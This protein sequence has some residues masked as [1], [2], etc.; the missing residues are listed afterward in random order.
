MR[1]GVDLGGT[2]IEALALADD[3]TELSRMR[4]ST[5]AQDYEAL[6][7]S[8]SD[9]IIDIEQKFGKARS[10]GFGTPGSIAPDTGLMQNS[11]STCLNGKNLFNDLIEQLDRPVRIANDADCFTLSEAVDGAARDFT[12]VFGVI[13]G[14]GVGGGLVINKSLLS[15][16][17][18]LTG[19]WGHNPL[20]I[21]GCL[22]KQCYCGR[23]GCVESWI[24]GPAVAEDHQ[25]KTGEVFTAAEI[26]QLKTYQAQ[27]TIDRF[28]SRLAKSLGQVI[29]IL[30]PEC[31]VFGGGLSNIERIYSELPSLVAPYIMSGNCRTSFRKAQ[32]GDS[33]GVRGAA[34]LWP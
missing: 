12:S 20:V 17:N 15:G 26:T 10:L 34:W 28:L 7:K 30:D 24:S 14:T 23:S 19:E 21:D 8:I 33:S 4:I 3:G 31:I 13:L 29:N 6:L 22:P 18:A 1:I 16:P 5:P 9:L 27:L 2:K 25:I 11:N 32:H